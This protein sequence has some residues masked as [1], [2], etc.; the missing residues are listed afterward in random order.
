ML[1][2]EAENHVDQRALVD[3]VVEAAAGIPA[4]VARRAVTMP[5]DLFWSQS[6]VTDEQAEV[7][8][9]AEA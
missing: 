6:P 2:F 1:I 3:H 5:P 9:S 8:R 4:V 7:L